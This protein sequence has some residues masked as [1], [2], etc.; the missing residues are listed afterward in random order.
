MRAE[1]HRERKKHQI[2]KTTMNRE[3]DVCT[4]KSER[5]EKNELITTTAEWI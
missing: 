1:I 4:I 5:L 2:L 3:R